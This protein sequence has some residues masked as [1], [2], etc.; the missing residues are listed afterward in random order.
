[1]LY[2][3]KPDSAGK[4][5][6]IRRAA[7]L[8][9][10][11]WT[12]LKD[13]PTHSKKTGRTVHPAGVEVKGMPYSSAEANDKFIAENVSF[14]TLLSAMANPDSVFYG[15]SLEGG[16]SSTYYGIVCNGLVRFCL[17]IAGRYNCK[18]WGDIPGMYRVKEAGCFTAGEIALC[19][20]LHSFG[21]GRNHVALI[22]D[23]LRDESGAVVRVEVS[24]ATYFHCIRQDYDLATFFERYQ[25]FGLWRYALIDQ[26]P[27]CD[28]ALEKLLTEGGAEAQK[29]SITVDYGNKS[30]YMSGE[31][32]VISVFAPGEQ[33]VT[34]C[35]NGVEIERLSVTGPGQIR[36]RFERGYYTV[37]LAESEEAAEFCVNAPVIAHT[38]ENE[39]L[40][41]TAD[42]GDPESCIVYMEFR[43]AGERTAS[44]ASVEH[45]SPQEL[46]TGVFTRKIPADAE[47]FK[48]Y[49]RN[50]YGVWTHR[51]IPV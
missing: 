49:F 36:R 30:N 40:T 2:H 32:T 51:M 15:K 45:L 16:N 17:G 27:D 19:D 11:C 47:N 21:N 4:A 42:P 6:A 25:V 9:E 24:E 12:P 14:E 3:T 20:V 48:V 33:V 46:K 35:R 34:I 41:I 23:L 37:A 39:Y 43:E 10:F 29:A 13:V 44:L 28:V 26:V 5:A 22:T 8:T 1:M 31:E 7:L 50:R 18:R 38:V